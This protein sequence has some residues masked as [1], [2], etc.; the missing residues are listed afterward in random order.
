MLKKS[1]SVFGLAL[2]L[3][4]LWFA[5]SDY[6]AAAP[7]AAENLRGLALT[8]AAAIENA[9]SHD[10]SFA[11]LA[12]F[13]P[14]E[15]AF[16][17]IIDRK[18]M[19]RFHSN[20]DLIGSRSE[21]PEALKVIENS[22]MTETRVT[23]GTGERAYEFH[24]PL[25][26]RGEVLALSLTLHTYRTDA[27]IRRARLNLS[28]LISLLAAGWI[29]AAV[30]YRFVQR[31][32]MHQREMARRESLAKLGEMGAVLAHEI[33]NPLAGIK[34]FA[35][36][37][38]KQPTAERNE[39]FAHSIVTEA[40]RMETL[41]SNLLAYARSDRYEM[42]IVDLREL[43]GHTVTLVR[44]EADELGVA[45]VTDCPE[46]LMITGNR[47]RLLQVLLNLE[48]NA[49]QAMPE[50]GR[51]LVSAKRT[52]AHATV[53][54]I[55]SGQGISEEHLSKIFEP[56]FTTKVRGTG[57]GLAFCKKTI[58]EHYGTIRVE[59]RVGQGTSVVLVL[60]LA[61]EDFSGG[62]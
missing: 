55:D 32:Q 60:P 8:L 46:A 27:V 48:K 12:S 31:E 59:S 26:V 35:Q 18:G 10:P 58:E 43:I 49:L 13:H 23:L 3:P 56:F 50:G 33:R 24:T 42:T 7:M 20:Q 29:M 30:L 16:F 52:G 61:R 28:L 47:D 53:A 1:L 11:S 5:I 40:V 34:G 14:S 25:F 45:V 4:L 19:I 54:V 6:R 36:V 22:S 57:L 21:D 17:A 9:S 15:V 2:T 51:L 39:R 37:I 41:V 44:H 62:R 38:E